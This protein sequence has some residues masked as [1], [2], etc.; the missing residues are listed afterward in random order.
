MTPADPEARGYARYRSVQ[1]GDLM[2]DTQQLR[3]YADALD[4]ADF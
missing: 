2:H 3:E 1:R 4:C